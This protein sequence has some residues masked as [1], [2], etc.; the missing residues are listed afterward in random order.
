MDS[1]FAIPAQDNAHTTSGLPDAQ[2]MTRHLNRLAKHREANA[3]KELYK[4]MAVPG[5]ITMAGGIPHPEVFPFET[6]S[7][8]I[9]QYNAFPLNPPRTPE[10][11]EK[12]SLLSWLF[13]SKAASPTLSFTIP[14]YASG[15][16][17]PLTIELSTSL[18]YQSAA[19]PPAL[20]LFL[21][22][23]VSKVYKPAYADWDVLI[24]VGATDGWGKIC[25]MLLEVGDAVL[26]EEWT[27]PGAENT[28]V[29]YEVERVPVKMDGEGLLPGHLEDV[30][31]NWDE[32]TRGKR[33]PHVLYT[34]P[35]GQN[36]TGATMQAERKQ[37]IYKICQ[38]YDVVICE[39]EPYYCLYTGE[40]TPKDTKHERSIVAHRRIEAEMKEGSEGN[41]A[42]IDALPPSFL[43]FD[44]DGR[45]IRMDTFSKTSAPGSRL[46]WITSSPLF[47]ERL[48]RATEASTQ[49]PSGF[50]TALTTSM[51]Q[52]WGFEGYIRWLRGIKAL[53][54]MR[55]TW[56]CDI[57]QEVFHLEFNESSSLFPERSRTVTCYSKRTQNA[58]DEK[59]GKRG[60]A[61]NFADTSIAGMFIFLGVHFKEHPDYH[62]LS[63]QGED[64]TLT[65]T[66]KLWELLADNLVLFAPGWGFDAGGEH[67]IGGKGFGYYRLAFSVATHKEFHDGITRFSEVLH[68]FFRIK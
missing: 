60:R 61:L 52:Q 49:A 28:F 26:V 27:Y 65:L 53:Y 33:R 67:A 35:T 17:N 6:I 21:R 2:D 29:P 16:T 37:E 56:L 44:T 47:I 24:N 5:M 11:E 38:K 8:T 13:P 34:I 1:S 68:Q 7:A 59:T 42:F 62:A 57:F 4:Y 14:K 19:G 66:K 54:N 41:Q 12:K 51:I 39:D 45:V 22:E 58:W 20:P 40:W 10:K 31:G 32:E 63:Q 64:A 15:A 3:L 50:A 46:G 30:L 25:A 36:P 18:Q 43:A 48:T 9:Y 55:K 23:Y